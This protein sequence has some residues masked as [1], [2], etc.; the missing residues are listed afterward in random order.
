MEG[1]SQASRGHSRRHRGG[2]NNNNN[3]SR[4]GNQRSNTYRNGNQA[5]NGTPAVIPAI[6]TPTNYV[7]SPNPFPALTP[8]LLA[9]VESLRP[10]LDHGGKDSSF[11]GP[12]SVSV[13][14][15]LS[16]LIPES[17]ERD[18]TFLFHDSAT[19]DSGKA[20]IRAYLHYQVTVHHNGEEILTTVQG[21]LD[22]D[23]ANF[24]RIVREACR[25]EGDYITT[26]SQQ[27][28]F[29]VADEIY[30]RFR[31]GKAVSLQPFIQEFIETRKLA[32]NCVAQALTLSATLFTSVGDAMSKQ[33]Y[34]RIRKR[35]PP[36]FFPIASV[37]TQCVLPE[38]T[39]NTTRPSR[40]QPPR[41]LLV[42]TL[43]AGSVNAGS[44][45]T[46]MNTIYLMTWRLPTTIALNSSK[47]RYVNMFIRCQPQ[48]CT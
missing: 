37:A 36:G 1:N 20:L 18:I 5:A 28:A 25:S 31:A 44:A 22:A 33:Q 14:S 40:L 7:P 35:F 24:M 39:G 27:R 23:A 12:T 2:P 16:D 26:Y 11:N 19:V 3:Q 41:K 4:G 43:F 10:F 45:R 48:L 30:D 42:P 32:L 9:L 34:M 46:M 15:L 38:S 47:H 8:D 17:V 21:N 13:F 6:S 29:E